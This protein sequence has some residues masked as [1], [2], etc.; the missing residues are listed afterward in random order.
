MRQ[1]LRTLGMF[2]L[3]AVCFTV[4]VVINL[5]P[6]AWMRGLWEKE[7]AAPVEHPV[8]GPEDVAR[9]DRPDGLRL[10]WREEF[11]GP[12]GAKPDPARWNIET[13]TPDTG[14]IERN[15]RRN[16]ALDGKGRLVITAR[17][18]AAGKHTSARI[19]TEGKFEPTYGRITARIKTPNGRGLWPA[20]WLL[21]GDHR[22]NPWPACGEIDIMERRG[23]LI[24]RYYATVQ[25]PG[26][27][28]VG[29][30][31]QYSPGPGTDFSARFHVFSLDWTPDALTF[32]IDGY[33][34]HTVARATIPGEW[35]FDH[36]FFV[37]LNLAVGG[38]F[39]GDP[40]AETP[41]PARMVVDYVRAYALPSDTAS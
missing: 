34:V 29:I 40:D 19:T 18:T 23:D 31:R 24:D 36:P 3:V 28:G 20:F 25:G 7:A 22:E 38:P 27:S 12:R 5:G 33:V 21:G 17:K 6:P 37:V 10:V 41:F 11:T 2:V 13:T 9:A 32:M 16:V 26:Y 30:S 15:S 4:A 8:L 39:P 1:A 14:E 35:V